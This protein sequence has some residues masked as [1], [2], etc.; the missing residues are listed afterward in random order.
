M[1]FLS[2]PDKMSK[3]LQ[4]LDTLYVNLMAG[5]FKIIVKYCWKIIVKHRYLLP[6]GNRA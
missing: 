5:V 4:N 6:S 3:E 1:F 2:E